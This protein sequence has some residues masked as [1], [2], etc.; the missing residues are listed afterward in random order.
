MMDD[1]KKMQSKTAPRCTARRER[2]IWLK[3]SYTIVCLLVVLLACEG[4]L[5]LRAWIRYGTANSS[6]TRSMYVYDEDLAMLIPRPG[7][8]IVGKAIDVRINSLGF[9]GDEIPL[10]KA[11]GTF[12]IVCTGASTTF[13]EEVG[14]VICFVS[15]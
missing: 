13:C 9:R 2:S 15:G 3:L 5:R 14:P 4:A 6:G 1:S 7:Y 10:E 12:R 8:Q 11:P